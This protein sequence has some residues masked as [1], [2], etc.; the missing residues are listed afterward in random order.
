MSRRSPQTYTVDPETGLLS[1]TGQS[2]DDRLNLT[3]PDLT[4]GKI[5][6][7][8]YR[9]KCPHCDIYHPKYVQAAHHPKKDPYVRFA[10]VNTGTP[11]GQQLMARVRQAKGQIGYEIEGVPTVVGYHNGRFYSMYEP[12]DDGAQFRSVEDTL[13]YG[14]GI[15]SA[16]IT[17]K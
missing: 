6:I 13:E 1:L 7:L 3:D 11:E 9:P 8:F 4:T 5:V 12:S 14:A 15:G 16:P 2:F 17:Y 10:E